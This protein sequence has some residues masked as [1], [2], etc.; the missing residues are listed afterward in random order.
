FPLE[1]W[2]GNTEQILP[3]Q[4]AFLD[5]FYGSGV[6][7]TLRIEDHWS[8]WYYLLA[9]RA[10]RGRRAGAVRPYTVQEMIEHIPRLTE[11]RVWRAILL[12]P[13]P[14]AKRAFSFWRGSSPLRR[15]MGAMARPVFRLLRT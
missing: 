11:R 14:L 12:L 4:K 3:L 6:G 15:A 8:Y 2:A 9:I 7:E 13:D 10:L 1:K 5:R